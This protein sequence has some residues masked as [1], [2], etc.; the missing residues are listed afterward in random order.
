LAG[1]NS[2]IIGSSASSWWGTN[3]SSDQWTADNASAVNPAIGA[4]PCKAIGQGWKMPSQA[5][6][7]AAVNAASISNPASAFNSKLKLPAGGYRGS[8]DGSF[9]FVGQR[10]YFWSSDVASTGGKYLYVGTTIA[11]PSSGAPRGQGASVR[12][13][14]DFTSLSTSDIKL[15]TA[16]IYP[17]PTNGILYI[18]ADSAIENVN[19]MNII[20]QKINVK[21]STDQIDMQGLPKGIYIVELKLKNGQTFS[22]KISKN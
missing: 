7:T 12:C 3:S 1:I 6:W 9:T 15:N 16:G 2:F 13:I 22:K 19:V 11:N 20:G 8:T 10:G 17:N 4:D 18:K 21:F 14:K 5:D